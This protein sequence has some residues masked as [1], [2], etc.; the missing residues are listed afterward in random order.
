LIQSWDK[1]GQQHV[2]QYARCIPTKLRHPM[3]FEPF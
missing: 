3:P 2:S 1:P